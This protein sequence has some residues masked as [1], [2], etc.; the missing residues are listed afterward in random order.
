VA[1]SRNTKPDTEVVTAD[2]M[3][4]ATETFSAD[5]DGA[6]ITVHRGQLVRQGDPR[7]VAHGSY[8][9]QATD[10]D[11]MEQATAAPGEHRAIAW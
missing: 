2:Q 3:Y 10:A 11:L 8:F 7:L 9:R 5:V 4:V 1:R 6:A